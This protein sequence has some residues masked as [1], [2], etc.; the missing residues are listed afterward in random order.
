[1]RASKLAWIFM[2]VAMGLILT[3]TQALAQA[4]TGAISGTVTDSTGAAV[5]G[6]AVTITNQETGV[7]R[8]FKTN[9]EGFYSAE[10]LAAGDFTVQV[11]EKGF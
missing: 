4:S 6:A 2:C 1:M 9:G 11:T 8:T 10:G 7:A 5:S 3:A